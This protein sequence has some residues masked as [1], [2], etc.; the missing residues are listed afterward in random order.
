MGQFPTM[1]ISLAHLAL[2]SVSASPLLYVNPSTRLTAANCKFD[3]F[4]S[5]AFSADHLRF[6]AVFAGNSF[7]KFL[8]S[9]IRVNQQSVK[10]IAFN[11][12]LAPEQDKAITI[13]S[14]TFN[15][16][17][18][19]ANGAAISIDSI[20]NTIDIAKT[21]FSLCFASGSGGAI[22][23]SG[24]GFQC[25]DSCFF[26]CLAV[27]RG[28]AI[29]SEVS[30]DDSKNFL[31]MGYITQ[32]SPI[33]SKGAQRTVFLNSG[34]Q[35]VES[36]NLTNNH[37]KE[38]GASLCIAY[39]TSFKLRMSSFRDNSGTNCF[40]LHKL[41]LTDS[42]DY[43]NIIGNKA[44]SGAGLIAFESGEAQ[45]NGFIFADNKAPKHFMGSHVRFTS[46]IFDMDQSS[47][48]YGDARMEFVDCRRGVRSI[49]ERIVPLGQTFECWAL[50]A[51]SPTP[52]MSF[53]PF[54][55]A[56]IE[57]VP[58]LS[59][60]TIFAAILASLGAVGYFFMKFFA[61]NSVD[62]SLKPLEIEN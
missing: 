27:S 21:G 10:G 39:P 37:V 6:G 40:W 35:Y 18:T 60:F 42:L 16:V 12:S 58:L 62:L 15:D 34:D 45:I 59:I 48:N 3:R 23:F 53:A 31:K 4:F 36:V 52:S 30:A 29:S 9:P 26:G 57:P 19:Q 17:R 55:G 20:D 41:K 2:S 25:K 49:T 33:K 38:Q 51:P 22:Y 46:C 7:T 13:T 24:R 32:C 11:Q 44:T 47:P 50:G 61:N 14:C 43:C 5:S 54:K 8:S 28:Q 1:N 56:G